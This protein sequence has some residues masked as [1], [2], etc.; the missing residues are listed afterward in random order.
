[1]E[2]M[3]DKDFYPQVSVWHVMPKLMGWDRALPWLA[4]DDVGAIAAKAFADPD[5]F[6]GAEL[7]LA[8]DIRTLDEGR[9]LWVDR[10]RKPRGFP[11]PTWLFERVAGKDLPT[12]WRWL[13]TEEVP[14]DTGPTLAVHPAAR[15]MRQ[16]VEARAAVG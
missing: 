7:P 15:T 5:R 12:M 4:A 8:A 11:M 10:G 1:M 9:E 16:W 6:V 2:L 14:L 3:T 13:R